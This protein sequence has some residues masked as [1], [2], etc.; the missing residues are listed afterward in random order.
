VLQPWPERTVDPPT[1]S[2]FLDHISSSCVSQEKENIQRTAHHRI[3]L[4]RKCGR[5]SEGVRLSLT[6]GG[7]SARAYTRRCKISSIISFRL[8]TISP[9]IIIPIIPPCAPAY[10]RN[11]TRITSAISPTVMIDKYLCRSV[12]CCEGRDGCEIADEGGFVET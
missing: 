8:Y 4:T 6:R 7:P 1:Q 5:E 2:Q 3:R 12:A 10:R 11:C 9:T